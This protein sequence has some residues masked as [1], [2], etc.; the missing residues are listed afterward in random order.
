MS[1]EKIEAAHETKAQE[2][3][4]INGISR[5][6]T[7]QLMKSAQ[8]PAAAIASYRQDETIST[9]SIGET[10]DVFSAASL[11]KP[12]FAYLILKLIE[13]NKD[14]KAQFGSGKFNTE[15]DLKTPLYKL[16]IDKE[17]EDKTPDETNLFLKKFIPEHREL[18]KLLNAEMVLSH[19]TGL[20]IVAKEPF[21]FQFQPGTRYAYSGPGIDCLQDAIQT[22]TG[23]D[24]ETLAKKNVF[25]DLKMPDSSYGSAPVAANSLKTTALDYAT[26]ITSWINDAKL[27]YAFK[28]GKPNYSMKDDHLP[29]S[30]DRLVEKVS[31][32][33]IDRERVCWGLGIGLVRNDQGQIIGAYHTGDMG[34]ATVAWRA[35]VGATID[36]ESKRC[37]EASVYLTKSTN[38][39]ILAD[40]ILPKALQ[41]ALNYFFPTYG[42]ARNAE[43]LDGTNFHGMNPQIL[44]PELKEVAYQSKTTTQNYKEQLQNIKSDDIHQMP[45]NV[46]AS[47]EAE[48]HQD[49]STPFSL[50]PKAPGEK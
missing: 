24:I 37:I 1:K 19:R 2:T 26:F 49:K 41:P 12:V 9:M 23:T 36:P 39:H 30:E 48:H 4:K 17:K 14:N 25:D 47:S 5:G 35:G 16:F 15:F 8:I 18:A 7:Q 29:D 31:V 21:E 13:S 45:V 34:D 40:H 46:S 20:H 11:S 28:P 38:G 32:P 44:K 3:D 27:N 42:F 43:E 22:L 10:Q 6:S 33:D 50:T